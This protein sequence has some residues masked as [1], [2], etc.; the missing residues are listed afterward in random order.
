VTHFFTHYSHDIR[1]SAFMFGWFILYIVARLII[2]FVLR[3][4]RQK[5]QR[6]RHP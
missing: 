1:F 6:S 3:A 2:A 5:R 4:T